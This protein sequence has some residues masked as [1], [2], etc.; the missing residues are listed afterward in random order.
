[1]WKFGE[2][3]NLRSWNVYNRHQYA[4]CILIDFAEMLV[5][6]NSHDFNQGIPIDIWQGIRLEV[7]IPCNVS[8]DRLEDFINDE[9][10]PV[11]PT[12]FE[13]E[14]NFG[15]PRLLIGS[16]PE[17]SAELQEK[18][19]RMM[20]DIPVDEEGGCTT[21]ADHLDYYR[22]D[23][24][25]ELLYGQKTHKQ[26][27]RNIIKDVARDILDDAECRGLRLIGDVEEYISS[28]LFGYWNRAKRI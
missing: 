7:R 24:V 16:A 5:S 17:A 27:A 9:V 6:A 1:M 25:R 8:V 10:I 28:L 11:L 19:D 26:P 15:K 20:S 2:I 23:Y 12:E 14:N 3:G 4:N 22:G 21:V 13:I 18:L